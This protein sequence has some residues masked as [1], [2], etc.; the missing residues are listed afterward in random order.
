M[1][2]AG[3]FRASV[4]KHPRSDGV[5]RIQVTL[6]GSLA[7]TG[8]RHATEKAIALG[9]I[10][11][12]P[13]TIDPDD[14][15][16]CFATVSATNQLPLTARHSI[17]FS[18]ERDIVFELERTSPGH[19]NTLTLAAFDADGHA[20][21][22]ETWYSVGG[23][24]I[25]REGEETAVHAFQAAYPF[26]YRSAAE[27]LSLCEANSI[28]IADLVLANEKA[29]RPEA[30]VLNGID[31]IVTVMFDCIERG[32]RATGQLPGGLNV[33][34]RARFSAAPMRCWGLV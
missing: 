11:C 15:D 31:R 9:L 27:L 16:Q 13:E 10:G 14:A 24:F 34:R 32:I 29:S 8:K 30:D 4:L 17:Y 18:R 7:W 23:G 22:E 12:L 33:L 26:K 25:L 3:C 20:L 5:V 1:N 28:T 6:F 2:A 19:S 21:V